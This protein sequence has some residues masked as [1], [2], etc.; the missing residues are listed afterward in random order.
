V[1]GNGW[2]SRHRT[3]TG[4]A[5][6]DTAIVNELLDAASLDLIERLADTSIPGA[7]LVFAC[8]LEDVASAAAR[9]YGR[10]A[11]GASAAA[12]DVMTFAPEEGRWR[13]ADLDPLRARL[14]SQPQSC[15][16]LV[17]EHA[18]QMDPRCHDRLLLLVEEP[19]SPAVVILCVASYG[20]LP[21]T[22]RGRAAAELTL[23]PPPVSER[24]SA[25]VE[26][27]ASASAAASAVDLAGSMISLALPLSRSPELRA[28]AKRAL[29]PSLDEIRPVSSAMERVK[30]LGELATWTL[31]LQTD[32]SAGP[33]GSLPTTP[34]G[35]A[36]HRAL[37]RL[38]LEHRRAAAVTQVGTALDAV[39][40]ELDAQDRLLRRL[41]VPVNIRLAAGAFAAET[42]VP[43]I[44]SSR[45]TGR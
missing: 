41:L 11:L 29:E 14:Q 4:T 30:L 25:L 28:A 23:S 32:P 27:G 35:N 26:S 13:V 2:G 39:E 44:R 20:R 19:P 18:D 3:S 6:S 43:Q 15:H 24:V 12:H 36:Q 5:R 1:G 10:L 16:V 37:V 40:S 7:L 22:L 34:P 38:W 9:S 31:A 42:P 17:L 21:A 45:R 8:P 33:V